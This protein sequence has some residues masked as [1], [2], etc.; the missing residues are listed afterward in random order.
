MRQ[1]ERLGIPAIHHE[2]YHALRGNGS[3]NPSYVKITT[4]GYGNDH[5]YQQTPS[6]AKKRHHAGH[7]SKTRVR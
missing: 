4:T 1:L 2:P 3:L 6:I 5:S 7:Q